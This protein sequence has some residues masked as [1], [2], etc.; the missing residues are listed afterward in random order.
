MN[1][2][3]YLKS[4]LVNVPTTG[5]K[6]VFFDLNQLLNTESGKDYPF[7]FWDLNTLK[8]TEDQRQNRIKLTVSCYAID[9]WVTEEETGTKIAAW[10]TLATNFRAYLDKLETLETTYSAQVQKKNEI[11]F[12]LFDRGL[13][14]VDEEIAIKYFD[15]QIELFC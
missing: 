12:E 2:L 11:R 13:I 6:E 14:S 15:V 5:I 3:T 9:K 8:G 10:D 7:V 1:F 4:Y